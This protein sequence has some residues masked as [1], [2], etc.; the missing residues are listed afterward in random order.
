MMAH[1][2]A[3]MSHRHGPS[4]SQKPMLQTPS[5]APKAMNPSATNP[6]IDPWSGELV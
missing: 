1:P 3:L 5:Q 6:L 2:S 4:L